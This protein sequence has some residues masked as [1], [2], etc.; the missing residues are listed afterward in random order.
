MLHS[1]KSKL[2]VNFLDRLITHAYTLM[3]NP[4]YVLSA[5]CMNECRALITLCWAHVFPYL[6]PPV[7][8]KQ[9]YLKARNCLLNPMS[10]AYSI[11]IEKVLKKWLAKTKVDCMVLGYAY[12]TTHCG[13]RLQRR[14]PG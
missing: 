5:C 11:G 13:Q 4:G 7:D 12:V 14:Q 1:V 3:L 8:H 2:S 6:S 9:Q 10:L